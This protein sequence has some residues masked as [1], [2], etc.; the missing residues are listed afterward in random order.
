MEGEI[1]FVAAA[2]EDAVLCAQHFAHFGKGADGRLW[3]AV[4]ADMLFHPY[5]VVPAVKFVSTFFEL[6]YHAVSHVCVEIDT[7][8]IQVFV[9]HFR[10]TDAGFHIQDALL[11]NIRILNTSCSISPFTRLKMLI[12]GRR[13]L[14]GL[15]V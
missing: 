9:F 13:V 3:A 2:S 4:R 8:F 10:I 6:A 1:V 14:F 7:V 12:F 11:L 15:T 5:H